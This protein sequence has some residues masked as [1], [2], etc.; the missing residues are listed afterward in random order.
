LKVAKFCEQKKGIEGKCSQ[1][2]LVEHNSF[3]RKHS[4]CKT[5][6]IADNIWFSQRKICPGTLYQMFYGKMCNKHLIGHTIYLLKYGK[7]E[8]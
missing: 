8:L 3:F 7:A 6:K 2:I 5:Q 4:L 1:K